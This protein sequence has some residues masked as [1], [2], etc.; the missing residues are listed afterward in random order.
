MLLVVFGL[1][2]LQ[3]FKHIFATSQIALIA[4]PLKTCIKFVEKMCQENLKK[5]LHCAFSQI[6]IYNRLRWIGMEVANKFS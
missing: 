2:L 6:K 4:V 3:F 1:F 5:I